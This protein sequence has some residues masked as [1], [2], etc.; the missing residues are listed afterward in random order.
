MIR[1]ASRRNR[2]DKLRHLLTADFIINEHS[3]PAIRS[4]QRP[5]IREFYDRG[6][7]LTR[8]GRFGGSL[9]THD[10]HYVRSGIL[11]TQR[12]TRPDVNTGFWPNLISIAVDNDRAIAL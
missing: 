7:L 5:A 12:L 1:R 9:R 11:D 2:A 8:I 4:R 10:S 6:R 3:V